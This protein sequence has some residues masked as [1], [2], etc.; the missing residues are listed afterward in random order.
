[1]QCLLL[2]CRRLFSDQ[3]KLHAW[4]FIKGAV[5]RWASANCLCQREQSCMQALAALVLATPY[6]CTEGA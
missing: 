3:C 4:L 1:M 5:L 6:C 2:R